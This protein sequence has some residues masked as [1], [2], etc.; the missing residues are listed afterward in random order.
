VSPGAFR[1]V[2]ARLFARRPPAGP[3]PRLGLGARVR[4]R[5]PLA[6]SHTVWIPAGASG[7]VVGWDTRARRVSL[8]LDAPRTVVT[9]PWAWVEDAPE[10]PSGTPTAA[11][12][13]E[14]GRR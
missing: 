6:S 9:V 13:P 4:L 7:I 5:Q 14:A 12:S 8:E 10:P 3:P 2:L 1:Q 11:G